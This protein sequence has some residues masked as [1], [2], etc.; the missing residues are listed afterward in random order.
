MPGVLT[1]IDAAAGLLALF[2]LLYLSLGIAG[3]IIITRI[4]TFWKM[5]QRIAS[6]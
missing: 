6:R 5:F 2:V 4:G 3:I 1:W